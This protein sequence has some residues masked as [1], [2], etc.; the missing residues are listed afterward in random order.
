[1]L[2]PKIFWNYIQMF[3]CCVDT[4]TLRALVLMRG[5]VSG[6]YSLVEYISCFLGELEL[7]SRLWKSPKSWRHNFRFSNL[8]FSSAS[9]CP[10]NFCLPC[11][12]T[13]AHE[14]PPPIFFF[15]YRLRPPCRRLAISPWGI[16]RSSL[17]FL[18]SYGSLT[19]AH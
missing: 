7:G 2:V 3:I 4:E 9:N 1:M 6:F 15:T 11:K 13:R 12:D 18:F 8:T 14:P 16:F 10:P 17:F 5:R 19:S